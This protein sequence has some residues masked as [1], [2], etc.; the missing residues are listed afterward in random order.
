MNPHLKSWFIRAGRLARKLA[1][2]YWRIVKPKTFGSRVILR[3]GEEVLLV[4]HTGGTLWM[5]PGGGRKRNETPEDCAIREIK[6][7]LGI[8]IPEISMH[9]F[10]VYTNSVEGKRD[11]IHLFVAEIEKAK[12]VLEWEIADAQWF[13]VQSL[14]EMTSRA[15]RER[16]LEV[17]AGKPNAEGTWVTKRP[18]QPIIY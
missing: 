13:P 11:T 8:K 3:S 15:T 12:I 1:V 17:L 10:G 16:I 5:F 18:G 9:L 4:K 14:P 7:E 6:E 2:V